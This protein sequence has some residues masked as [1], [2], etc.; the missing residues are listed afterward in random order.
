MDNRRFTLHR[1]ALW[2][3]NDMTPEER[4]AV[5]TAVTRLADLPVEQWPAAGATRLDDPE[6]LYLLRV[7][8][9]WRAFV[10]PVPGGLPEVLDLALRETLER[11]A[12]HAR[13][14]A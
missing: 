2:I 6:P 9:T 11:F 7:D 3:F 14:S 1:R 10:Q 5:C 8:D 4:A 13:G 12:A